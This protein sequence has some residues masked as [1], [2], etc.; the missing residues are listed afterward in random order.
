M[1]LPAC[2]PVFQHSGIDWSRCGIA[3]DATVEIHFGIN[4]AFQRQ[5]QGDGHVAC[6]CVARR[7]DGKIAGTASSPGFCLQLDYNL[8]VEHGAD[9]DE[10]LISQGCNRADRRDEEGPVCSKCLAAAGEKAPKLKGKKKR[11]C[12]SCAQSW[13][14]D[15][16]NE[17]EERRHA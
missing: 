12:W 2:H 7:P 15:R 17:E 14:E 4:P 9:E 11:V 6:W 16:V 3:E 10:I 13:H 8:L 5:L 1:N